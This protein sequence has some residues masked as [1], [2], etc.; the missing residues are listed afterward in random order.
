M[1]I[2]N[3]NEIGAKIST[4]VAEATEKVILVSP[5]V[6]I[7]EWKKIC[8]NLEK[9]ISKGIK[10]ELYYRELNSDNKNKL[11][12]LG[13]SLFEVKGLHTKLYFN[14][15]RVIVSSM[16]LYEYSDLNS[17]DLAINYEDPTEY[18]SLYSYFEKYIKG[19]VTPVE[20]IQKFEENVESKE[21][22]DLLTVLQENLIEKYG[23]KVKRS[24]NYLFVGN[25]SFL[26][27][28]F[29]HM[30]KIGLKISDRNFDPKRIK[31]ISKAL[32]RLE[33][34]EFILSPPTP[35]YKYFVYNVEYDVVDVD[36]VFWI[37]DTVNEVIEEMEND[38]S[39]LSKFGF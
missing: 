12:E 4:L 14:D 35:T 13:I 5:Y 21:E 26:F 28:Y 19:A 25:L 15:N 36:F 9:A 3:P 33:D 8:I 11:E 32:S 29:F 6:S 37:I 27:D 30:D 31:K 2:V 18:D 7:H 17:I 39:I 23:V 38:K 22:E 16:N 24:H 10:V 34:V 1:K 20:R